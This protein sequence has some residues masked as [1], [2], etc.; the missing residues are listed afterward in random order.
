MGNDTKYF[1]VDLDWE[2]D[3]QGEGSLFSSMKLVVIM[4]STVP[5][6]LYS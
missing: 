4:N 6:A 5:Q 1:R 2:Q 3:Y